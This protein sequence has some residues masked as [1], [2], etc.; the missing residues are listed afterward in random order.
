MTILSFTDPHVVPNLYE[1]LSYIEHKIY[2]EEPDSGW[3]PLTSIVGNEI[4]WKSM[5][6]NKCLITSILQNTCFYVQHKKKIH[7]V[8]RI[9]NSDI[10]KGYNSM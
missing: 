3:F 8:G 1:F 4:L 9:E 10:T 2:F 7:S 5:G 6:T